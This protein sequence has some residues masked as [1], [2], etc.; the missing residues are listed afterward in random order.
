MSFPVYVDCWRNGQ[1]S[2]IPKAAV[3]ALFPV[4]E[5]ERDAE[6]WNLEYGPLDSCQV[7]LYAESDPTQIGG[8][9]VHRPCKDMRLWD[10][11]AAVLR[12][13]TLVL[14]WPGCEFALVADETMAA[15]LPEEVVESL[16]PPKCVHSGEEILLI[17]R[18]PK[19]Q[20]GRPDFCPKSKAVR[21]PN[22]SSTT[23]KRGRL[24]NSCPLYR[25][26]SCSRNA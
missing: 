25:E 16:G 17:L 13:G 6:V 22:S 26:R 20:K 4:E 2:T 15:H 12:L 9:C 8:F 5:M 14:Y 1:Q 23:V 11:L 10:A 19:A 21:I 7:H 24:R 3:L 18:P